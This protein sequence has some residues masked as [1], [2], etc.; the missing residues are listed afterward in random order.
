MQAIIS[1]LQDQPDFIDFP[2]VT[3][4]DQIAFDLPHFVVHIPYLFSISNVFYEAFSC[5][6]RNCTFV[7]LSATR[8]MKSAVNIALC[9][10]CELQMDT[11]FDPKM[12]SMLRFEIVILC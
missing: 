2:I 8:W 1:D 10:S 7:K 5:L 11:S 6:F 4:F 9:S 12:M 3:F